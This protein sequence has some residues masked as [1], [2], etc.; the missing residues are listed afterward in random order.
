MTRWGDRLITLLLLA[1][2]GWGGWGVLHWLLQGL[3]GPW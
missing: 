1:L 2:L 3:S